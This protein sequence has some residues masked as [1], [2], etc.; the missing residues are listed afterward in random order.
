MTFMVYDSYCAEQ[1]LK[2]R[3]YSFDLHSAIYEVG[4]IILVLGMSNVDFKEV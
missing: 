1:I 3:Y 4:A 2:A